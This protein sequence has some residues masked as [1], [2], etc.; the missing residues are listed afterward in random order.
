M[1]SRSHGHPNGIAPT[2]VERGFKLKWLVAG[3][4]AVSMLIMTIWA[5]TLNQFK[6]G[7]RHHL[8]LQIVN[9]IILAIAVWIAIEGAIKF[10]TPRDMSG[11]PAP[12]AR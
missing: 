3:I 11:T 5:V 2:V 10:F 6:F 12:V 1:L 4:P 8:L 7:T 9:V